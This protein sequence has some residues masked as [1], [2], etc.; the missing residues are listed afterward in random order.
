MVR[1]RLNFKKEYKWKILSGA[2]TS[3]IRLRTNLKVG[4]EA[5]L[6]VGGETIGVARITRIDRKRVSDL[7]NLDAVKDGFGSLSELLKALRKHYKSIKPSTIISII[8]FKL[9]SVKG[10]KH[11]IKD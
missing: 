1:K 5:Y 4:D 7:T 3:T 8:R 6:V 9:K 11:S 10:V 2:K